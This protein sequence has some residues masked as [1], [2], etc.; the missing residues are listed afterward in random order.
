M[1]RRSGDGWGREAV[2]GRAVVVTGC[3]WLSLSAI[4]SKA[5]KEYCMP[6][7]QPM[8]TSQTSHVML[9]LPSRTTSFSCTIPTHPPTHPCCGLPLV[10]VPLHF[11][12]QQQ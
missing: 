11:A 1:H 8:T 12:H 9:L 7:T 10:P 4:D 6:S 3:S 2:M 5:C